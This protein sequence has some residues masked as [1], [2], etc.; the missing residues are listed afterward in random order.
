VESPG[1]DRQREASL[2]PRELVLHRS[3][4]RTFG[5]TCLDVGRDAI[6]GDVDSSIMAEIRAEALEALAEPGPE[7]DAH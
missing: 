6:S 7:S 5:N 3:S 4:G 2:E 1:S